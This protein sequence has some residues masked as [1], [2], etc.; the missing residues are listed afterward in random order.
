MLLAAFE[1]ARGRL[2]GWITTFGRVPFFYYVVHI[3]LIHTLAVAF[4]WLTLGDASW[5]FGG[6]PGAKPAAYGLGLPGVYVVW[7]LV[8]ARA[9]SAVPLV[10]RAQAA[11][12]RMVVELPVR[13]APAALAHMSSNI[14][15]RCCSKASRSGPS[16]GMS[17]CMVS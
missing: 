1:R 11:P 8:V 2:A 10:R 15:L 14:P 5:L 16:C 12:D 17:T 6:A 9:L 3:Y 13:L 4:A 7:A